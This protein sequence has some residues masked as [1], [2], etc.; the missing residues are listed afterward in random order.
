MWLCIPDKIN[1]LQPFFPLHII[2][3]KWYNNKCNE[4]EGPQLKYNFLLNLMT[5]I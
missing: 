3:N 1:I 4:E 5:N 2:C